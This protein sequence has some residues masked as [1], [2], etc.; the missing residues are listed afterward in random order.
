M[1]QTVCTAPA[2]SWDIRSAIGE[3]GSEKMWVYP[4][5]LTEF[6]LTPWALQTPPHTDLYRCHK[7]MNAFLIFM[8]T[9]KLHM[10]IDIFFL[11]HTAVFLY[12]SLSHSLFLY[13]HILKIFSTA[14]LFNF[15]TV[16]SYQSLS[17]YFLI[18][19]LTLGESRFEE[20]HCP[21]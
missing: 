15:N 21:C 5:C 17:V 16:S 4:K 1:S 10:H 14:K 18:T 8:C 3:R 13:K 9:W 2:T 6:K 11:K 7:I 19:W 20:P 12:F